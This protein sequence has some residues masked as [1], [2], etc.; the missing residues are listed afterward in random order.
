MKFFAAGARE[1]LDVVLSFNHAMKKKAFTL[2]RP[3]WVLKFDRGPGAAA[4]GCSVLVTHLI[5][6][7]AS[8]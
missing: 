2:P 1:N 4:D 5:G 6:Y 3:Q 7:V 8:M